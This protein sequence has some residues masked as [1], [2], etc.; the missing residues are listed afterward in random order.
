M[1][2]I[3]GESSILKNKP[4]QKSKTFHLIVNIGFWIYISLIFI[5]GFN[6]WYYSTNG[7]GEVVYRFLYKIPRE[8]NNEIA[9]IIIVI[10]PLL[11]T[12][13][14]KSLYELLIVREIYS[15][16][17]LN[18]LDKEY[19]SKLLN[20][21]FAVITIVITHMFLIFN[22]YYSFIFVWAYFGIVVFAIIS[23]LILFI[24]KLIR[25]YSNTH[26]EQSHKDNDAQTI[27]NISGD[28]VEQTTEIFIVKISKNPKK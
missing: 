14:L 24:L 22:H 26:S 10:I 17:E 19:E 15:G 4:K 1:Y 23:Y 8:E 11:F 2:L 28:D 7:S 16:L 13:F 21:L 3:S 25:N 12:V 9:N 6:N 20:F 27:E 5:A 18:E